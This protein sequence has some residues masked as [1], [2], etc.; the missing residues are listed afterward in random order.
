MRCH[1]R[2][3]LALSI[4]AVAG[5]YFV[6]VE[7]PSALAGQ[8]PGVSVAPSSAI[9]RDSATPSSR[10][11]LNFGL[12]VSAMGQM[13]PHFAAGSQDRA[14]ADMLFNGLLRYQPGRAPRIEPDLAA[15]MPAF[16]IRNGRQ[17]W[18]IKLRRGVMFHAGPETPAYELTADDVVYSLQKSADEKTCAYAGEYAGMRFAKVDPYTVRIILD[19]PLSAILFLPKLTDYAGGFIISKRAMEAMGMEGFKK[20]PVGT[21]PFAFERYV[22]QDK[23]FLKAHEQYFRGR[24]LLDGVVFHLLPD[25]QSRE[26]ALQN[27]E[28]DVI[29]GS[30]E[31]GWPERM[32]AASGIVVDAHGVGE[33]GTIYFNTRMKPLNDVRV[34]RAIAYAL[35]REAFMTTTS[36]RFIGRVYS[37]VPAPFL[38]GGLTREGAERFG[39][40]YDT[41]LERARRLLAEAG[42]PEGFTLDL[43]TS[44]KRLYR[45]YYEAL[46]KQLAHIGVNCRVTVETHS[47]MH[48]MI[49]HDPRAIVIYV[50]WRPNADVYLT[51]FFHSDSIVVTGNRPD[52][53]FAGYDRVDRLIEAARLEINPEKQVNLW[54]QAQIRILDDMVAYPIMYTNQCYARRAYVDYGHAL[55]ATMALYP[56]FTEKTRIAKRP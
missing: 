12:H 5:G 50:A 34:R 27:G 19:K 16:K 4:L 46:R 37:P 38:P 20:H 9:S 52:T 28:L 33:V 14:L 23:L 30:G 32:E 22:P 54:M 44:E 47:N 35:S 25:T 6:P 21:G 29:S 26:Q 51:R 3:L 55:E 18:T 40:A 8:S 10:S 48:K 36:R 43:I 13:D 7:R 17:E 1:L 41:D 11:I 31:K 45:T 56:Q 24:P 39:L 42:Y 15:S 49:R 2:G 53:N